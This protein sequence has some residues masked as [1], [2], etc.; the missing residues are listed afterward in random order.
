MQWVH[1]NPEMQELPSETML[2]A[3]KIVVESTEAQWKKQ[4]I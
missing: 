4:V 1:L 3:N 2:I